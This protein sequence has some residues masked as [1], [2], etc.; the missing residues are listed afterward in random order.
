MYDVIINEHTSDPEEILQL[1]AIQFVI[2]FGSKNNHGDREPGLLGNRI[3]EFIPKGVAAQKR[4]EQWEQAIFQRCFTHRGKSQ[5][6]LKRE[7]EGGS[8]VRSRP[9]GPPGPTSP[10]PHPPTGQPL[11]P[12][13]PPP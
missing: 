4:K 11:P 3:V 13:T 6:E 10:R 7:Y 1:A 5:L 9:S 12:L 8:D 2:K